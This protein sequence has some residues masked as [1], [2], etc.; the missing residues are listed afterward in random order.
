VIKLKDL[1]KEWNNTDFKKLENRWSKKFMGEPDGLTEFE[2]KGG[3]DTVAEELNVQG[4]SELN[5]QARYLKQSAMDLMKAL[6]KQDDKGVVDEIEYIYAKSKLMMDM[7]KDK[8][9]QQ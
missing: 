1:L 3:K 9:Y 5:G 2:R 6:K 7:L 8:R 4:Y